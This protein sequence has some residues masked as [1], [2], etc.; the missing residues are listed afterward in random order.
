[1]PLHFNH[2]S[3]PQDVNRIAPKQQLRAPRPYSVTGQLSSSSWQRESPRCEPSYH[4]AV[5]DVILGMPLI[6]ARTV[7]RCEGCRAERAIGAET[8]CRCLE[9]RWRRY[10]TKCARFIDDD[11]CPHCLAVG[12][13]NGRQVRARLER[14]L[15]AR[16]GFVGAVEHHARLRARVES[17]LREFS[18]RALLKPLPEWAAAL[19]DKRTPLP[20]GAEHSR[21]KMAAI[22]ELRLEDAGVRVA[23]ESLGYLGLPA[24]TKLETALEAGDAA[25]MLLSGW[26]GVLGHAGQ[27][28]ELCH[29]A[30]MLLASDALAG[31]VL[32][33]IKTRDVSRVVDA[34]VRRGRAVDN[35]RRV[36]GIA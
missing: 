2:D 14:L 23:L 29:A 1:M 28:A 16:S 15:A 34:A 31:T 6:A 17:A 24:E 32:E 13:E 35:C 19:A 21:P 7:E 22:S 26:D 27:E 10:C 30:E 36:L 9:P 8:S 12:S 3:A 25:A 4:G 20:P 5:P 11:V 33:S 18:L